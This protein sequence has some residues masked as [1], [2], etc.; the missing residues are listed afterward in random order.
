MD[1]ITLN[2]DEIIRKAFEKTVDDNEIIETGIKSTC[3]DEYAI[4][5]SRILTRLIKDTGRLCDRFASDLLFSCDEIREAINNDSI[6]RVIAI[7]IRAQGVDGNGYIV[8]HMLNDW[9]SYYYRRIYG[10]SV[11]HSCNEYGNTVVTVTMR[12]IQS[13]ID[14]LEYRMRYSRK[15]C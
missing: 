14:M 7:G 1:Q 5:L 2:H 12:N 8:N 10:V 15:F 11:A 13:E 4:N 6:N 3:S 9:N